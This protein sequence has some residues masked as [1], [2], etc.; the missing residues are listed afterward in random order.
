[1]M[2][3]GS[4]ILIVSIFSIPFVF[5]IIPVYGQA[6]WYDDWVGTDSKNYEQ[7]ITNGFSVDEFVTGLAFPTTMSFVN[8]DILVLQKNN[9]FVLFVDKNGKLLPD[10]L[11]DLNVANMYE[12]G[13]LG[14]ISKDS[15]VYIYYTE[16]DSDGQE[17]IA[18]NIYKYKWSNNSL[19]DPRLVKSLPAFPESLIH[20]GGIMVID[21]KDTL[22]AV[23]G[24]QNMVN[25]GTILQNLFG[26]PNDTGVII[27]VESDDDYFAIGIR[28]SYGLTIDPITGNMWQT[29]NGPGSFDEINLVSPG[30]NSGWSAHTGPISDA[31]IDVIQLPDIFGIWKSYLQLSFAGI[32]SSFHLDESYEYHDPK[33]S[34]KKPVAPT[35][36]AF[37]N[38][39]FGEYGDWIFVG[40]CNNGN[41]YKFKLNLERN[42][43]IFDNESLQDLVL[44]ENDD[45]NEILFGQGFGCI[46]DIKFKDDKMYVVS[47]TDGIIYRI[48]PI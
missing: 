30:F 33:F 38:L 39:S 34:W 27:P 42:E 13:A 4:L 21:S 12:N 31:R 5:F 8:D 26:S 35:G 9:G 15:N 14:I 37:S 32:I 40:D 46:T 10:P 29:E 47:L 48:S 28:N 7:R 18:N 20:N 2:S 44:N 11:L 22:Y 1:M 23:I 17:P 41:I 6:D 25:G 3:L 45:N 16:S 24:D 19:Q 43:L 36:I